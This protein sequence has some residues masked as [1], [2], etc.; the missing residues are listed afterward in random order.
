MKFVVAKLALVLVIGATPW[1]AVTA[2]EDDEDSIYIEE[3]LVTGERGDINS[4][5][6]S[7]TVTGF[8]EAMIDELGINNNNDL[9]ILTPGLQIGHESPDSGHGNHIYLRGIGSERH[10]EF[11]QDTAV[12]TYVD[13]IYTDEVYGLEQ[14]NLFDIERIEVAR[15]PQGTTG[16]RSAI[17]GSLHYWSKRPSDVFDVKFL[18]EFTDQASQRFEVAFGGPIGDSGFMY[19]VRAGKWDGDGAQENIGPGG[20]YDEPDQFSITPQLRYK[21]DRWDINLSWTHT[22]DKGAPRTS[23]ALVPRGR[24]DRV[25][26]VWRRHQWQHSLCRAK[27][28]FWLFA[29]TVRC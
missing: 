2:Q 21:N 14:G 11:F 29:N 9:E 10:Q 13:G 7:M 3:I 8:N 16:G 17:A 18:A 12:A 23:V 5:D 20:A 1:T 4:L 6:R 15:G 24:N 19:R 22:E 26:Y 27:S 25:F 28:V